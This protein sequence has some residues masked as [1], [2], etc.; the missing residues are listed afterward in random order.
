VGIA[1]ACQ[2]VERIPEEEHDQPLDFIL[3]ENELI[4]CS[5][6]WGNDDWSA[7]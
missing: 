1:F 7:G 6:A 4:D 3:T 5:L 2:E